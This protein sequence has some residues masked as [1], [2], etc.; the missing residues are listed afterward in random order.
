MVITF[1]GSSVFS[2]IIST[3]YPIFTEFF[4]DNFVRKSDKIN[5]RICLVMYSESNKFQILFKKYRL[6]SEFSTLSELGSALSEKGLI[7]DDSIFSHW[8]KGDRV[9]A[10]HTIIKLIEIFSERKSIKTIKDANEFLES[11]G[12]GYLTEQEVKRFHFSLENTPFQVPNRIDNFTGREELIKQIIRDKNNNILLIQGPAGVGK[13]AL[14]IQLAYLLKDKFSDGVLWFRLD[15]SDVMD[16]LLSI[17]FAY[18]TDIGYIQDKEIRATTVRTILSNKKVLLILDNAEVKNEIGLLLPNNKNCFVIITSRQTNL[19]IPA[20]YSSVSLKGFSKDETLL[21]FRTVLGEQYTTKNKTLILKLGE[22]VGFLPLALHIFAKELKKESVNITEILEEV[23]ADVLSLQQLSYGDKNLYLAINLSFELL[24]LRTKKVFLS[25]AVFNGKDFSIEA[26][27]YVND[28]SIVQTKRFLN[29]LQNISLIEQSTQTRYRLHPMI[30]KFIREKLN[31]Q[32]LFL[33]AAKYYEQFL[34]EFDKN[35]LKS[36]PNIKQESDNVLYIFRKC[37]ELH[38]WDEVI[39]LWDPLEI[40][41]YATNQL[42]KTKY[43]YQ[44]VKVQ[45]T[46]INIF[47]KILILYFCFL[48]IYWTLLYSTGLRT[49]FWNYLYSFSFGLIP[50]IGGVMGF[51]IARSWGL[52]TSSLGKAVLFLSIGLF[53]WATGNLIWAFYNFILNEPVPYPSLADFGFMPGYIFW[54][55]GIISLP[56]AIGGKFSFTAKYRNILLFIPFFV[57]ALSYFLMVFIT[58]NFVVFAPFTSLL[59]LFFD[60]AY[61]ASDIIILTTAIAVGTSFKFFGG[62]YKLSIYSI[63][64][65]FCFQYIGD[66]LFSYTTTAGSFYVG[67]FGDLIF[68]IG[69]FL[70]TF[71]VLG[72]YFR[73]EKKL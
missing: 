36:Y 14:V 30:K 41:L 62:K 61:P 18:G 73:S 50:L 20:N 2:T 11:A 52:L 64:V 15:T 8:Q 63:L 26:V 35:F 5:G 55:I 39:K 45:K 68:T 59:K 46:G 53:S 6:R 16:I 42:N 51:F 38:Y 27:A 60:I 12:Q 23:E 71:G 1:P 65:G 58:K 47:Q 66:F 67:Y 40:L 54:T 56:R 22:K 57:F 13:T 9:P 3:G 24:D 25:L 10:R 21:L 32:T 69:F 19:S 33:K 49:S 17:A 31:N 7:Y 44:I 34:S 48:V 4:H 28:L 43:L 70:I 29:N 37:Y 72:F